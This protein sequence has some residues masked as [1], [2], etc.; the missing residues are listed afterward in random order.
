MS[1][2]TP[3]GWVII[4]SIEKDKPVYFVFGSF[5]DGSW[6]RNSSIV[7]HNTYE[8]GVIEFGGYTGSV[9]LVHKSGEERLSVNSRTTLNIMIEH[10]QERQAEVITYKQFLKEWDNE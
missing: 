7:Q 9:Y 5:M 8:D 6:R 10:N 2:H 1:L 4:K 3:Y